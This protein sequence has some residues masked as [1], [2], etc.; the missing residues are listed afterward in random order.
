[1]HTPLLQVGVGLVQQ[2]P[3]QHT[4]VVQQR[5]SQHTPVVQDPSGAPFG[6]F[7]RPQTPSLQ[8]ANW[9]GRPG[10][11][12]TWPHAPQFCVPRRR[13]VQKPP[14]QTSVSPH[15][16]PGLVLSGACVNPHWPPVQTGTRQASAPVGQS[17]LAQQAPDTH[18]PP[19]QMPS[20]P[21]PRVQGV[22]SGS[23]V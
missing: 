21:A 4:P 15:K 19:Q 16:P 10:A 3:S 2:T 7:S 20:L 17:A 8:T 9:Q 6:Q 14:Q 23:E 13:S 18:R 22:R 1:V 12:Q 5:P 11:G